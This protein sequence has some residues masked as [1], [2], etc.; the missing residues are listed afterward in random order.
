M[1]TKK[2]DWD[3][4]NLQT[5]L[6]LSGMSWRKI[7]EA[8]D[9]TPK[10]LSD[11]ITG[12]M[13]PQTSNLLKMADVF[14]VPLDYLVGRCTKEECDAIE[15]S[16]AD[17]FRLLRKKDYEALALS[18]RGY[19]KPTGY[20]APYPYNLLDVIFDEPFDHEITDDEMAGLN[21]ILSTLSDREQEIVKYRYEEEKTLEETGRILHLTRERIR[22]IEAKATRKMRHP[23]RFNYIRYGVEGYPKKIDLDSRE[24]ELNKREKVLNQYEEDLKHYEEV[25]KCYEEELNGKVHEKQL[26]AKNIVLEKINKLEDDSLAYDESTKRPESRYDDPSRAFFDLDLSVRAYN[27]LARANIVTVHDIIEHIR[28][29]SIIKVRNLGRKSI[30]EIITKIKNLTGMTFEEIMGEEKVKELAVSDYP[31]E[32][33]V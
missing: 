4:T 10:S 32:V 26:E 17:N 29:G 1:K 20:S 33:A 19:I 25:L 6:E 18:Y 7:C 11:Y 27:C 9:I 5:V 2:Y 21:K 14:A 15:E 8:C 24:Y 3:P 31:G 23:S 12:K 28:D 16:Y 22:Q 30:E 13:C